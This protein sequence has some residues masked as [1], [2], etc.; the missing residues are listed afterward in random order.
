MSWNTQLEDKPALVEKDS[1]DV[2]VERTSSAATHTESSETQTISNSGYM[3][4]LEHRC[5]K[6]WYYS[7]L[8]FV[9]TAESSSD[10]RWKWEQMPAST[11]QTRR[12]QTLHSN[13][14]IAQN[15]A[16]AMQSKAGLVLRYPVLRFDT[17]TPRP[18]TFVPESC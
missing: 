2:A 4:Q 17:P 3:R 6:L 13:R 15:W 10:S 16:T 9:D 8:T 14:A 12:I 7:T 11:N 1:A 18:R 5:N